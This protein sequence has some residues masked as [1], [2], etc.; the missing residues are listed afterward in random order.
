MT[1]QLDEGLLAKQIRREREAFTKG[2]E[3]FRQK[4]TLSTFQQGFLKDCLEPLTEAI[5]KR[6]QA[7]SKEKGKVQLP[8]YVIAALAAEDMA[9]ITLMT[10]MYTLSTSNKNVDVKGKE[11]EATLRRTAM[12]LGEQCRDHFFNEIDIELSSGDVEMSSDS[13]LKTILLARQ[14]NPWNATR[15]TREIV[16]AMKESGWWNLPRLIG[17]GCALIDLAME[18]TGL[19]SK[20]YRMLD[21]ASEKKTAVISLSKAGLNW[22]AKKQTARRKQLHESGTL[23]IPINLPTI[24]EPKPWTELRGGGYYKMPS[25]LVKKNGENFVNDEH[26]DL[27]QMPEVLSAV[28]TLQD[29][30]WRINA[31]VFD[32]YRSCWDSESKDAK[33]LFLRADE[34]KIDAERIASIETKIDSAEN[35]LGA[36]FY[37]PYQLD[38]RGRIY[39]V[40][41]TINH[42][43]D[44]FAR[45]LIEFDVPGE[46]DEASEYWTAIHLANVY[47]LNKLTL[48]KRHAW[49]VENRR[50]IE[51]LVRNPLGELDFWLKAD[52]RWGLLAAAY[53]WLDIKNGASESNLPIFI[54]GRCNGLQHLSAMSRDSRAAMAVNVISDGPPQDIYTEVAMKLQ[55]IVAEDR[56]PWPDFWRGKID[57]SIVKKPVMTTPYGVTPEGIKRQMRV[58]A[59]AHDPSTPSLVYLR[60]KVIEAL[61][62]AMKGPTDVKDWLQ[63]VAK[64]MTKEEKPIIWTTPVGFR[65][66]QDYREPVFKRLVTQSYSVR[67]FLPVTGDRPVNTKKQELGIIANYVHSMDAAHLIKVVNALDAADVKHIAVVHDSYGVHASKVPLM[68]KIIRQ[69]FLEIYRQPVLDRFIDEQMD[70]TGLDLPRFEDYGDLDIEGVL[71]SEYF[72]S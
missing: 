1:N 2:V 35:L 43:A 57:R 19:F 46:V 26:Y 50:S 20:A 72:F 71:D 52:E 70:R 33:S 65:V 10:V 64:E 12:K 53:A 16:D 14:T 61:E 23:A 67:Y 58:A 3:R 4:S 36:P 44:D 63:K 25:I 62:E 34:D 6:K 17:V 9:L 42:Q 59:R 15:R 68:N 30:S 37:F 60:D 13:R 29:T 51:S 5:Q 54:D 22:L 8:D 45:A 7:I 11:A 66:V 47:G 32:V 24:V 41:Q 18:T 55:Q 48:D 56:G 38:F 69:Q 21:A 31:R 27:A 40:P 49:C 28:N 39:A